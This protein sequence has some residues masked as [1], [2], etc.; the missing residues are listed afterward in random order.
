[1]GI[2]DFTK[3][4]FASNETEEPVVGNAKDDFIELSPK[5]DEKNMPKAVLKIYELNSYDDIKDIIECVRNGYTICMIRIAGL[6]EKDRVELKRAILKLKKTL[7]VMSG[8]VVGVDENW[9]VA[10][11][12]FVEIARPKEKE[13]NKEETSNNSI[14]FEE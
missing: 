5:G 3:K 11:P 1:M 14:E 9:V 6:H 4:L 2:M 8:D 13:E 12:S 10:I 7:Q